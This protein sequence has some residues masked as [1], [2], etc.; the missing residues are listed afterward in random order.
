MGTAVSVLDDQSP[1]KQFEIFKV[2]SVQVV[3]DNN[4]IIF[5][6]LSLRRN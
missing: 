1:E 6:S 2:S 5:Y 3:R 4:A